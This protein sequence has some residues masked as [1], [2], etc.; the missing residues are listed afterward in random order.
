MLLTY[1]MAGRLRLSLQEDSLSSEC[2]VLPIKISL[3]YLRFV[4][5]VSFSSMKFHGIIVSPPSTCGSG[6]A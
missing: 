4:T 5:H 3:K 6:V 2:Q 1:D